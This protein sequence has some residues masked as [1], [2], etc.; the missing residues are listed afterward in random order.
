M[1]SDFFQLLEYAQS[2]E[3]V[4]CVSTNGTMLHREICR[5]LAD[6]DG[7]FL[8]V[9]LDG[10]DE[11]TNDG[12]R[13]KGTYRR[14]LQ[15]FEELFRHGLEFSINT[16]LTRQS[17]EQLDPLKAL[18]SDYGASLRVSRFRPSGRGK[19]VWQEMAP[20]PEQLEAF[21]HWLEAEN[22]VLTGDSFFSLTSER[23]RPMGLDMCG[24]AKMTCCLSPNGN[25]FPCAFLQ[26]MEFLAGNIG[27][28]TLEHV[29]LNSPIFQSFRQ[30]AV[31]SCESCFRFDTCHGGCPAMAYHAYHDISM[32]DPECLMNLKQS[33]KTAA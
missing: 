8:Q 19:G 17:F 7:L 14:V 27:T 16:V 15:A 12:I 23:R 1:R 2:K 11:E 24:A 28:S 33:V 26:E 13:G 20:S 22:Q 29:W 9:S 4:T 32:S 25:I 3:I 18:A 5:Q 21:A 30:L 6:M 10:V 31:H